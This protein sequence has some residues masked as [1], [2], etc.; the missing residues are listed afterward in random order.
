MNYKLQFDFCLIHNNLDDKT[1]LLGNKVLISI[2]FFTF[3]I[4]FYRMLKLSA[5]TLSMLT[6]IFIKS[7]LTYSTH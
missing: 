6:L 5:L 4:D 1:T 3:N 7:M 2:F